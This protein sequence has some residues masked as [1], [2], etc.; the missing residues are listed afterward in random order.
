MIERRKYVRVRCAQPIRFRELTPNDPIGYRETFAVDISEGGVRF[1]ADRFVPLTNKLMLE[2]NLAPGDRPVK[3]V[4]RPAWTKSM[5]GFYECEL[6]AFF[7]D[8]ADEDRVL[9]R[10][11]VTR[12]VGNPSALV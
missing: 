6:G 3:A 5:S 2:M 4:A 11:F 8:M 1:R 7:V 12:Q 10:N 9:V